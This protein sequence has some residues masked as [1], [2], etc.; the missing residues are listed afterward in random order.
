MA[1][2]WYQYTSD[3]G[4]VYQVYLDTT[5]AA[6]GGFASATGS[7]PVLPSTLTMRYARYAQSSVIAPSQVLVPY[8]TVAALASVLGSTT[9]IG[10][11]QYICIYAQGEQNVGNL[12]AVGP[13]G[14]NGVGYTLSQGTFI[15]ASDFTLTNANQTY[16]ML[17][18]APTTGKW[19]IGGN[20]TISCPNNGGIVEVAL[21]SGNQGVLASGEF[22][23]P[24]GSFYNLFSLW[25]IYAT[26]VA[27]NIYWEARGNV[28]GCIARKLTPTTSFAHAT[29]LQFASFT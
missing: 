19:L 13:T 22:T 26:S 23:Y 3:G 24:T 15:L 28:A 20:A 8:P 1:S 11:V 17:S 14:A 10:G 5:I 2:A 9:T 25:A 29:S 27:D 18:F 12:L 6:A 7:E 21:V 16:T 4:T